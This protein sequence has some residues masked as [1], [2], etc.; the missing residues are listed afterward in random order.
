MLDGVVASLPP[1]IEVQTSV[2][3]TI[4]SHRDDLG[5]RKRKTRTDVTL[6]IDLEQIVD[7]LVLVALQLQ[8][9]SLTLAKTWRGSMEAAPALIVDWVAEMLTLRERRGS[10][11]GF[12]IDLKP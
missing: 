3:T 7:P 11:V 12:E 9:D 2:W 5:T 6:R 10:R 4:L 8:N 1:F